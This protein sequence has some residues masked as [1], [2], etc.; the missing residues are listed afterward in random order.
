MVE[1]SV[2]VELR[3]PEC[4]ALLGRVILTPMGFP[5]GAILILQSVTVTCPSCNKRVNA[6]V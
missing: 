2:V 4:K 5:K 1:G 3:C 6:K